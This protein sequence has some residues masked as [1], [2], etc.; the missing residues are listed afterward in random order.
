[1]HSVKQYSFLIIGLF[2]GDFLV[3]VFFCF[4]FYKY[5]CIIWI[6]TFFPIE[7]MFYIAN[8]FLRKLLTNL[9]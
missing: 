9:Y 2:V 5:V 4:L 7:M 3:W 8:S 6:T 1:M